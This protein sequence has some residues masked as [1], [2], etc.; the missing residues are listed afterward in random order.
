L[1]KAESKTIFI[2][3]TVDTESSDSPEAVKRNGLLSPMVYGEFDGTYWGFP[4]I[5]EICDRHQCKATFFVSVLQ[6]VKDGKGAFREICREIKHKGHDV[7]LHPHPIWG[8]GKRYLHD[9]SLEEQIEI[10]REG[11]ELLKTWIGESPVAHRAGWYGI[12]EDTFKALEVN[13]IAV[14]SSMFYSRPSCHFT[15]TKNKV[16]E[17]NRIAELPVTI[18]HVQ[19]E[20]TLGALRYKRQPYYAKTD[21]DWLNL[22]ELLWFVEEAMRHNLRVIDL[23]LHSYSFVKFDSSLTNFRPDHD[24]AEKFDRLLSVV[25][26]HPKIEVITVKQFHDLYSSNPELFNEG[27]DY[28]P[29]L[30]R[31]LSL[32]KVIPQAYRVFRAK[33]VR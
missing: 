25:T 10:I 13:G 31:H 15:I 3:I 22:D 33:V 32:I 5:M 21:V 30:N 2:T 7:Q 6:H 16:I 18:C 29:R 19:P 28:V 14:D 8:Y 11:A 27:S 20:F 23:F 24:E 9:F 1:G 12:N 17:F 4:K 26:K